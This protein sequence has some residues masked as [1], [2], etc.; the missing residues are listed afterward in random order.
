MSCVLHS[1]GIA[2]GR[3][4]GGRHCIAAL[5][6]RVQDTAKQMFQKKKM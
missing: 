3:E 1:R 5:G 2:G 4:R 6:G